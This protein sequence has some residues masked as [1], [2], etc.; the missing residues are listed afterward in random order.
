MICRALRFARE[1]GNHRGHPGRWH[2]GGGGH[3]NCRT[4]PQARGKEEADATGQI[5]LDQGLPG[6]AGRH[7]LTV[8]KIMLTTAD[9]RGGAQERRRT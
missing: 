5:R 1:G 2:G 7:R 8:A 4:E 6:G 9:R 3:S